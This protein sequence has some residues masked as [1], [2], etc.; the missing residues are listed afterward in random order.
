MLRPL[1]LRDY[2]LAEGFARAYRWEYVGL[3]NFLD[4]ERREQALAD[5]GRPTTLEYDVSASTSHEGE[6][7]TFEAR[8]LWELNESLATWQIA[9]VEKRDL[10]NVFLP[11]KREA[12]LL[13]ME[14]TQPGSS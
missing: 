12:R 10:E 4:A 7:V 1:A 14:R 11:L 3:D 2:K 9:H 13:W 6:T 8:T 5:A